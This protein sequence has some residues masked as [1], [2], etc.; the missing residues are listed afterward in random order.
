MNTQKKRGQIKFFPLILHR[1]LNKD[2]EGLRHG[3]LPVSPMLKV[4]K[5]AGLGVSLVSLTDGVS[6]VGLEVSGP[7]SGV[8]QFGDQT[9]PPAAG[10]A[11]AVGV[12]QSR[13]TRRSSYQIMV[14]V[15]GPSEQLA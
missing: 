6:L 4:G 7:R 14:R 3:E 11:R 10:V 2:H 1:D 13:S 9:V 15:E 8:P 12:A 5:G